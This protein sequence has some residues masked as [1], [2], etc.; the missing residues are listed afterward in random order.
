MEIKDQSADRL[1]LVNFPYTRLFLLVVW[2]GLGVFAL[3]AVLGPESGVVTPGG[4]GLV[5]AGTIAVGVMIAEFTRVTFDLGEETTT[6]ATKSLLGEERKSFPLQKAH[7]LEIE[8]KSR[9]RGVDYHYFLV[10]EDEEPQ[11]IGK[12]A[13]IALRSEM[14]AIKE[15][16]A[17][18]VEAYQPGDDRDRSEP[19]ETVP[20]KRSGSDAGESQDIVEES[21]NVAEETS[22]EPAW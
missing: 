6:V 17:E 9:S 15:A 8:E 10:I 16:H 1:V 21:T 11:L 18:V 7:Q 20:A 3:N 13:G 12:N 22:E 19:E 4:L 5:A 14:E 2:V